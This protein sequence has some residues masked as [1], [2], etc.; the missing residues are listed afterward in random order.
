VVHGVYIMFK[1][2]MIKRYI[3]E[4]DVVCLMFSTLCHDLNHAG[5][6]NSFE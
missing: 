5:K 2:T 3:D 4:F 1:K 6:T